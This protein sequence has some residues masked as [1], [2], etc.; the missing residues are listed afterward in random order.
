MIKLY[1]LINNQVVTNIVSF[2]ETEF[3]EY[4]RQND[5]VID[6]HEVTPQPQI[7][8]VLNGNKLELPVNNSDR[9]KMEIELNKN[10]RIFGTK[11]SENAIDRI[12]ARNKILN[13]NGAQVT[14]I[15]TQLLGVEAL[16]RTGALGTARNACTQLKLVFT[17]YAD[18]F[19][20]VIAEI[21]LFESTFGL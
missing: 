3:Q 6:I 12:G 20:H 9:E 18:I 10:K 1:A 11:L 17:E 14:A 7:G 21:N 19:D 13:K 2:E 15:L 8:W 5:M 16:L 4:S